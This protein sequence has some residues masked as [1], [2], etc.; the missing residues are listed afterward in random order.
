MKK[1]S[2]TD[3]LAQAGR[4][5]DELRFHVEL[6]K[7]GPRAT[8]GMAARRA[9]LVEAALEEKM[10]EAAR[11]P[12]DARIALLLDNAAVKCPRE[13]VRYGLLAKIVFSLRREPKKGRFLDVI[14]G[15][16]ASVDRILRAQ[17][18]RVLLRLGAAI[19]AAV[20]KAD[21]DRVLGPRAKARLSASARSWVAIVRT[22][23]IGKISATSREQLRA[24]LRE[25]GIVVFDDPADREFVVALRKEL[26]LR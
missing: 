9:A 15:G 21:S 17:H 7:G 6:E 20:D 3:V 22:I 2:Q 26:G 18:G 16:L 1:A 13:L 23:D 19:R 24:T 10:G 14:R 8:R 4:A 5:F 25:V 12:F 11:L